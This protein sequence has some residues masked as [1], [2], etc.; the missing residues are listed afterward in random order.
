MM[1]AVSFLA[2]FFFLLSPPAYAYIGPGMG[3]G[4]IGIVLGIIGSIIL[5]FFAILYYPVKRFLKRMKAAR[6]KNDDK[7]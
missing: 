4:G 2:G 5:A 7:A 6:A 1:K 3:L